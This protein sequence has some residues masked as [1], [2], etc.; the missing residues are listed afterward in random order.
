M[1][2]ILRFVAVEVVSKVCI[3][4]GDEKKV[5][6]SIVSYLLVPSQSTGKPLI[7]EVPIPEIFLE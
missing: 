4:V 6:F 7:T 1:K 2:N 3:V 5:S